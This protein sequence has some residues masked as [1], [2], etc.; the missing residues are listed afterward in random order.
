MQFFNQ[1][2]TF[3]QL[4][5]TTEDLFKLMQA[6]E[7][8]LTTLPHQHQF[9]RHHRHPFI[10]VDILEGPEEYKFHC[11]VP[12]VTK[13]HIKVHVDQGWLV[14]TGARRTS[15]TGEEDTFCR[16]ELPHGP[17]SRRVQVPRVNITAVC[18][19]AMM[20]TAFPCVRLL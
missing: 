5:G 17:F 8:T 3:D 9:R 16:R 19:C 14:I 10:R 7:R 13:E 12:G 1:D 15:P 11:D 20:P 4:L 18:M 2:P 6:P